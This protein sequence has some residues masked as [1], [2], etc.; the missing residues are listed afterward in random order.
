MK[1]LFIL[2]TILLV[3]G[4][5]LQAQTTPSNG[6]DFLFNYYQQTFDNLKKNVEGLSEDQLQFQ[7]AEDK[8]SISQC[9]E[10]IVFT[11]KMIFGFTKQVM[12]TAANPERRKEIKSTDE[13]IINGITDRSSKFKADASMVGS[14]KYTNTTDALNDLKNE[15]ETILGYLSTVSLEDL[16]NHISDTPYGA[17]DAFQSFLFIA[18]HTARHTLQI[19]EIKADKNFPEK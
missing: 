8:W 1:Q 14:G 9:L 4:T 15:R 11:E 12:D 6:K 5:A 18:G 2:F 13:D 16:R 7:P 10:H 3:T 17:V 19:E